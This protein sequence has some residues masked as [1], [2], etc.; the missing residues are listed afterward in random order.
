MIIPHNTHIV[1]SSRRLSAATTIV[2]PYEHEVEN[3]G[4]IEVDG[5]GNGL[6]GGALAQLST[7]VEGNPTFGSDIFEVIGS[8][9]GGTDA[10][11]KG[12]GVGCDECTE[13][14][15]IIFAIGFPIEGNDVVARIDNE[16]F[17]G[18]RPLDS[19]DSVSIGN[20]VV[21]GDVK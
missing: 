3:V 10:R 17:V 7:T 4:G 11:I 14:V 13:V 1:D 18:I 5:I 20:T 21:V 2:G 16:S 9:V 15:V 8:L 12:Y 19:G 6:P